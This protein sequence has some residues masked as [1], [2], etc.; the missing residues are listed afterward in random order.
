[1]RIVT[2]VNAHLRMVPSGTDVDWHRVAG[3]DGFDGLGKRWRLARERAGLTMNKLDDLIG[4]GGY[5]TRIEA[6]DRADPRARVVAKAAKALNVNLEWLATGEGP[7]ERG[8]PDPPL[9]QF[10]LALRRIPGLEA[11]L[12]TKTGQYTVSQ[13]A[14]VIDVYEASS[15]S[16]RGG[17]GRPHGGWDEYFPAALAGTLSRV[18]AGDVDAADA[19]ERAQM[20]KTARKRLRPASKK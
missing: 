2:G 19:A 3:D 1:M 13:V 5:S 8:A 16:A 7:M 9:A 11:W 4:Q 6:G 20:P 18:R 14:K 12:E 15:P 17:D 10:Q